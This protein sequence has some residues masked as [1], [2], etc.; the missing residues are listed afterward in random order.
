MNKAKIVSQLL[1]Q[2]PEGIPACAGYTLRSQTSIL[3]PRR[4]FASAPPPPPPAV[5]AAEP[6]LNASSS[7]YIE[8]MY[9][10]WLQDPKSVHQVKTV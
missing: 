10:A 9:Q 5:L 7:N 2:I 3:S 4:K 8:E 1:S 6:F